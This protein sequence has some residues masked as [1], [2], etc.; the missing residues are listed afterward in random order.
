M[1]L[2]ARPI[3]KREEVEGVIKELLINSIVQPLVRNK[4]A[5][6]EVNYTRG[7]PPVINDID[8]TKRVEN[9]VVSILGKDALFRTERS[10]GGEDFSWY[11]QHTQ[12]NGQ[13]VVGA[14]LLRLGA[15]TPK[16][17]P[18]DIHQSNLVIEKC[19]DYGVAFLTR[20]LYEQ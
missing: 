17:P 9:A 12:P 8:G 14:M 11:L 18:N 1:E 7:V 5:E 15:R 3:L 6:V 20:L 19:L 4:S 10:L 16:T 2:S 13:K